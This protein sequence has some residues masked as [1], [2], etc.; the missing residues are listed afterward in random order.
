MMAILCFARLFPKT[1]IKAAEILLCVEATQ[2]VD[3]ESY[4]CDR[5]IDE[6]FIV[7]RMG[8]GSHV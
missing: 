5:I 8:A 1:W 2:V 3:M 6:Y 4:F 7:D